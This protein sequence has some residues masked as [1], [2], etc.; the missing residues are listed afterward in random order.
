MVNTTPDAES[1]AFRRRLGWDVTHLRTGANISMDKLATDAIPKGRRGHGNRDTIKKVEHGQNDIDTAHL[2]LI[3]YHLKDVEPEHPGVKWAADL[4][5]PS[6][7]ATFAQKRDTLIRR[8]GGSVSFDYFRAMS[9]I[10]DKADL[11]DAP[12]AVVSARHLIPK[13]PD[14]D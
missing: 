9:M 2:A 8:L 13:R 6:E 14:R 10:A 1:V 7:G 4:L 5:S 12:P 11:N 3:L